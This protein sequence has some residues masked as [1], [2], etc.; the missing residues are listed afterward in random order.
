[1]QLMRCIVL[2]VVL[3]TA[4]GFQLPTGL[5]LPKISVSWPNQ[6]KLELQQQEQQKPERDKLIDD[7]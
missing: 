6:Q 3:V 7:N 1:M 4:T 2:L 5:Q